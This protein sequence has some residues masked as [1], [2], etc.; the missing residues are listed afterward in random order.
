MEV[1]FDVEKEYGSKKPRVKATI[2]GIPYRGTLVRMGTECHLLLVLKSIREQSGKTFGDQVKVTLE[3]DEEERV[4]VLP[5]GLEEALSRNKAARLFFD[6]L[7]YTHRR[8]YANYIIE[9]KRE[10]TRRRRVEKVIELLKA[11]TK[12]MKG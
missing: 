9:A 5:P 7:S 1:P 3:P 12:T 11:G 8:E 6:S 4:V 2:E 10:E